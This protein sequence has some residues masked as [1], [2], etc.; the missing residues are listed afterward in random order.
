MR[1]FGRAD[2]DAGKFIRAENRNTITANPVQTVKPDGKP[3]LA[4]ED[5]GATYGAY[6]FDQVTRCAD[7]SIEIYFTMST[8]VP[9]NVWL[10]KTKF[11]RQ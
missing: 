7:G 3:F 4:P 5:P 9:Y 11:K 10:M 1:V 2:E 6:L 8:W